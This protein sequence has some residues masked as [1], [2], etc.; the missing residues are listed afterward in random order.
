M[1]K[2]GEKRDRRQTCE[3]QEGRRGEIRPRTR[4]INWKL[5]LKQ[6]EIDKKAVNDKGARDGGKEE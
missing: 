2:D 4:V 6:S 1:E 5:E 3:K